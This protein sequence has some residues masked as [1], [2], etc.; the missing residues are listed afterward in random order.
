MANYPLVVL[1][2]TFISST[3][4]LEVKRIHTKLG[5]IVGVVEHVRNEKV[6]QF[7]NIPYAEP[8]TG[9]LRFTKPEARR[10]WPGTLDATRFGPSCMQILLP[11]Y[12]KFLPNLNQSE[13]CLLLNIYV[14][15][16]MSQSSN[17]S[18]MVWIHGGSYIFGQG[19]LYDGSYLALTGDVVV[20]TINYR[21]GV[22][23]FLSTS[24][25][26]GLR[27][28]YG[29]WD[30][31]MALQWVKDNIAAFGGNPNS[32]T[33]F[34]ESAGGFSVSLQAIIPQNQGLFQ[35]VIAQS[36]NAVSRFAYSSLSNMHS[37]A[38]LLGI[39]V[40]CANASGIPATY[41]G[42]MRGKSAQDLLAAQNTESI[43]TLQPLK[44]DIILGPVVDYD[45]LQSSPDNLLKNKRTA[46]SQFFRSLDF[47][48]G[49]V[50]AEGSLFLNALKSISNYKKFNMSDGIPTDVFCGYIV[51]AFVN[52]Y[53]G[54]QV[55]STLPSDLICSLY[56]TTEEGLEGDN[57]I[58]VYSDVFF[59]A[60]AIQSLMTHSEDNVQTS[61][62]QYIFKR[63]APGPKFQAYPPWWRNDSS[64]HG[65]E[66]VFLFGLEDYPTKLNISVSPTDLSLSKTMLK[67]WTNFAK[68]GNPNS[69]DVPVWGAYDVVQQSYIDLNTTITS[70]RHLYGEW[71]NL[72]LERLPKLF[73]TSN[74]GGAIGK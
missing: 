59:I 10:A 62:Y 12:N 47:M 15:R 11:A 56:G 37:V 34:G 49:N 21:L 14:P 28:N 67:Y 45:L 26:G 19:M 60:P 25:T 8:P 44:L 4:G 42:C 22:F 6:Y 73:D 23:G 7:R 30:Q 9:A 29:L 70:G 51:P 50:N 43:L 64:A 63:P 68:T 31:H 48:T 55:N 54:S 61:S 74:P 72:W 13:D 20:V 58:D 52:A 2:M 41:K 36:G 40:G 18:V 69:N 66:V 71:I 1:L 38:K 17:R 39:N 3:R 46:S 24:S 35:R 65:S 33:I 57:A 16:D 5:D 53:F 27:G 32:V